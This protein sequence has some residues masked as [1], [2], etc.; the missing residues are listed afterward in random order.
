ML[1]RFLNLSYGTMQV[2]GDVTSS[3]KN[4]IGIELK[5]TVEVFV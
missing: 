4:W 3:I 5:G 1:R 2:D